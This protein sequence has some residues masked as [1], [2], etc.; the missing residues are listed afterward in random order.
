M[1]YFI[2]WLDHRNILKLKH[3]SLFVNSFF[4]PMTG[5]NCGRY[6]QQLSIKHTNLQL[7]PVD[8]RHV[9]ATHFYHSVEGRSDLESAQKSTM[10]EKYAASVG[11]TVDVMRNNYVYFNTREL[12]IVSIRNTELANEY[13]FD[14]LAS[15]LEMEF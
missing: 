9:R 14:G 8:Y 15:P 10:L 2:A 3:D 6:I 7:S 13:L 11:Q 1:K 5:T 12:A 4:N